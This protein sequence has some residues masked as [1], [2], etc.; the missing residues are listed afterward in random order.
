MNA[1]NPN[2]MEIEPEELKSLLN[3]TPSSRT[4]AESQK[5]KAHEK[6]TQQRGSR[7]SKGGKKR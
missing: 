6:A 5:L 7:H 1:I 4:S 3:K 2:G